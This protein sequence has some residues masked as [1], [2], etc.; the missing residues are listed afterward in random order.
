[1]KYEWKPLK[2]VQRLWYFWTRYCLVGVVGSPGSFNK[3]PNFNSYLCIIR[4]QTENTVT[5]YVSVIQQGR[6]MMSECKLNEVRRLLTLVPGQSWASSN[7]D[8]WNTCYWHSWQLGNLTRRL[9]AAFYSP[10]LNWFPTL[11]APWDPKKHG[12]H[13]LARCVHLCCVLEG[14]GGGNGGTTQ[15]WCIFVQV[16]SLPMFSEILVYQGMPA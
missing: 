11:L 12:N 14:G 6:P 1:M 13:L 16:C 9:D 10:G 4:N 7:H 8:Y 3:L 15:Q 5:T 2:R